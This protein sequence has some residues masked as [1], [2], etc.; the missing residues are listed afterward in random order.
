MADQTIRPTVKLIAAGFAAVLLLIVAGL[1]TLANSSNTFL[2]LRATGVGFSPADAILLY[3]GY[4]LSYALFSYPAGR[5]SDRIGRKTLLVAGYSTYGLVYLLLGATSSMAAVCAAFALYGLYSAFTEGVEKALVADLAPAGI[6][7]T[8]IGLHATIIGIGLFPASFVA[9][10]LWALFG[11][12]ATFLF[13]GAVG[14][15]AAIGLAV[16]L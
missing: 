7:A 12:Q 13:G 9:G 3:L 6:R 14:L 8:A 16:L 10:Q 2:L 5:L 11:P 4:N 1:F 15:A